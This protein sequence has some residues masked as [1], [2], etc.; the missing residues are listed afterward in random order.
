[1]ISG[2]T[3][4]HLLL[5]LAALLILS[6]AGAQG[7]ASAIIA[8][9]APGEAGYA[10]VFARW[11]AA[12]K[13]ACATGQVRVTDVSGTESDPSGRAKLQA[14]LASEPRE[15]E[16]LWIVLL[17]HGTF[18]GKAAK[19]NLHGDDVSAEDL[20]GWLKEFRRTVVLVAGFSTSGAWLKP[21]A[22]PGRIVLT[23]TKSGNESNFAR[24]GGHLGETFSG[25][26]DLDKDGETSLLEAW[27]SAARLTREFYANEGRLATEH[28]LL[29]D[30]GDGLGTPSDWFSGVRL[31]KKPQGKTAA[32]GLRA[33]QI[34]LVPSSAEKALTPRQ[35]EA[36]DALE[37][38]LADLRERKASMP[39][40]DYFTALEVIL[41][42]LAQ[43]YQESG[44]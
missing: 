4:I 30:N 41:L 19:F 10:D 20:A 1:M 5:A 28:S 21:L 40:S 32:D 15:G 14:A 33:S 18:D 42:K 11:V 43:I 8:V 37:R 3:I 16:P 38:D 39:E 26:A 23:A 29:D 35:R 34:H 31:V 24:F 9:S 36:R 22:A 2:R 6:P 44:T 25:G 17:G 13:K 7:P 12:W 27:L